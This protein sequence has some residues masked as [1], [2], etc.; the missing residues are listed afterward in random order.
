MWRSLLFGIQH[1]AGTN[2]GLLLIR[3]FAGLAM[4]LSHGLRKVPPSDRFVQSVSDIG[5]PAPEWFAWMAGLSEF[6][7]GMFIAIGFCTRPSAFFLTITMLVAAFGR[8]GAEAFGAQEKALLYAVM[9][10]FL[11]IQGPGKYSVDY[12]IHK[13]LHSR[14]SE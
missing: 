10:L 7:G 4:A 3:L 6:V 14:S 13:K 5:F 12:L 8:H 9:A 1:N 2:P 11:L